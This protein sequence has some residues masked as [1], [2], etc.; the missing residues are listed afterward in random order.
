MYI[1]R[2]KLTGIRLFEDLDI[3]FVRNSGSPVNLTLLLGDN[4]TGKTTFLRCIAIGLCDESSAAGLV[5]ELKGELIRHHTKRESCILI[6][7]LDKKRSWTIKTELKKLKSTR[8]LVRQRFYDNKIEEIENGKASEVN[9]NDFPWNKLFVVGYGAGRS[10]DGDDQFDNYQTV[11]AVYTLFRYDQPL[12]NP[13]LCWRRLLDIVRNKLRGAYVEDV[14]REVNTHDKRI[15]DLLHQILVLRN[16]EKV[17]L[18]PRGIIISGKDYSVPLTSNAD[19]YKSTTSWIL[20][21]ISWRM[22]YINKAFNPNDMTG[23]VFIDEIEQHLH[24]NWQRYIISRLQHQFPK[25]QFIMTTHSPLP[26][27]GAADLT[28]EQCQ[29]VEYSRINSTIK[30]E[31]LPLPSGLRADQI[32]TSNA[33]RLDFTRNP[34]I[35][36]KVARYHELFKKQDKTNKEKNEYNRLRKFIDENV[37]EAGQF[38]EERKVR[39]DLKRL[40]K[41]IESMTNNKKN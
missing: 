41:E 28:E 12:Q 17:T 27:A 4:A 7:L 38:E 15:S 18:E 2:I 8:E 11:D 5:R 10:T 30:I 35:G 25:I 13:E 33:F 1:T 21:L 16:E 34:K 14:D 39:D 19:G 36:E 3:S 24:P 37:P 29:I 9:I 32:L 23:I 31:N 40:V 6:E 22:L 26:V 20:D